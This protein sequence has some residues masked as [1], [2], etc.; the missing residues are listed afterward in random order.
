M[1]VWQH[2]IVADSWA[3]PTVGGGT[4]DSAGHA[5]IVAYYTTGEVY[6]V[7]NAGSGWTGTVVDNVSDQKYLSA[8]A[9]PAGAAIAVDSSGKV[10]IA[11]CV[12]EYV[13]SP[14]QRESWIRYVTNAT[15]TWVSQLVLRVDPAPSALLYRHVGIGLNGSGAPEII[16]N[17]RSSVYQQPEYYTRTGGVWSG[18]TIAE[19][20]YGDIRL[21]MGV[22]G[23][24][25]VLENEETL[26][27]YTYDGDAWTQTV[28][29][30][31][32]DGGYYNVDNVIGFARDSAGHF[33]VAYWEPAAVYPS[34]AGYDL[35][36]ISE[37]GGVWGAPSVIASVPEGRAFYD[38]NGVWLVEDALGRLH[39]VFAGNW[40]ATPE[41]PAGN[42]C[43]YT[44][45]TSGAW[46]TLSIILNPDNGYTIY[47]PAL[48]L[49]ANTPYIG[50]GET[51]LT[52]FAII[53]QQTL[54]HV[55]LYS[56]TEV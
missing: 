5:H 47:R 43:A 4:T 10:H 38:Q 40:T 16:V 31:S 42:H 1:T 23:Y 35:V 13:A 24:P 54:G 22:D 25:R 27:L 56:V 19:I 14:R 44:R 30:E 36:H 41:I 26:N 46:S 8:T 17:F 3:H 28:I 11:Y 2:E 32:Y 55:Y 21:L 50:T 9:Y 7:A 6:Y 39:C 51:T 48:V 52:G 20:G 12:N 18:S 15:G 29:A 49:L 53:S 45:R 37:T 34:T 33:H